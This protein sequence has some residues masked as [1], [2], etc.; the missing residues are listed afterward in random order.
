M[1][2]NS[3]HASRFPVT[4]IKGSFC[5]ICPIFNV[6]YRIIRS[7]TFKSVETCLRRILGEGVPVFNFGISFSVC[8]LQKL[9]TNTEISWQ[10]IFPK[11][12]PSNGNL[13]RKQKGGGGCVR[14]FSE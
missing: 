10:E 2:V 7:S 12:K 9:I 1:W 3:A 5:A 11:K 14:E 4:Y 13:G 6:S 8:N